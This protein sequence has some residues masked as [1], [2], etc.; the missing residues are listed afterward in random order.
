MKFKTKFN[1]QFNVENQTKPVMNFMYGLELNS[2]SLCKL[3]YR[4]EQLV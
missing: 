1:K 3:V 2:P 4:R